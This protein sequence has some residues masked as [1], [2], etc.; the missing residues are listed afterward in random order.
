MSVG[1][2]ETRLI[3]LI[4]RRTALERDDVLL[5]I[6]DDAAVLRP[7]PGRD[8]VLA[9]DT[10]VEGVHYLPGTPAGD[11]GWKALA[12]NLSDLAAMAAE[13]AWALLSLTLPQADESWTRDFAEGFAAL[14]VRHRVSLVGGDTSRG[15]VPVVTVHLAGLVA[16]GAALRRDGA[17]AGD[18]VWV[19]GTLGDAAAGLAWAQDRLD[20]RGHGAALRARLDRPVPRVEAGRELAGVAGAAIDLSDGL[21]ADLARLAAASGVGARVELSALPASEALREVV[22]GEGRERLQLAGDDYELC[23]TAAPEREADVLRAMKAVGCQATRV[24][25][26][27]AGDGIRFLREGGAVV[28]PAGGWEHFGDA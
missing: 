19:T 23:F 7:P 15:A 2:G 11:V 1:G 16:P 13:P 24:G 6:G 12:V 22:S 26:I 25:E 5:G 21:A 10:L 28:P 17:L 8:L 3:E 14:A 20:A 9:T 18:Q 4:R 27:V